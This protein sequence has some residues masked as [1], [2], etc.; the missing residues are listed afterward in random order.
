MAYFN[1]HILYISLFTAAFLFLKNTSP[2]VRAPKETLRFAQSARQGRAYKSREDLYSDK[3]E[4]GRS[5]SCSLLGQ[6]HNPSIDTNLMKLEFN[7]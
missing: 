2:V 4:I 3:I 5:N 7:F 1:D 6:N